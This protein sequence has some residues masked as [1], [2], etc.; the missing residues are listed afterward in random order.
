MVY[1]LICSIAIIPLIAPTARAS[2]ITTYGVIISALG[3]DLQVQYVDKAGADAAVAGAPIVTG[4]AMP[5]TATTAQA[6]NSLVVTPNG[7]GG[8]SVMPF[9]SSAGTP[10]TMAPLPAVAA[11]A[12]VSTDSGTTATTSDPVTVADSG[13]SDLPITVPVEVP[14]TDPTTVPVDVPGPVLPIDGGTTAKTPEPASL[15]LLAIAS[16]GG[17]GYFRRRRS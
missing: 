16:V 4:T 5:V 2:S 13:T 11:T 7:S 9:G 12:P 10:I 14:V 17:I 3:N 15:T 1:G 8:I 6:D